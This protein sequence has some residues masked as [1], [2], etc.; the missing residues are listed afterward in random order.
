LIPQKKLLTLVEECRS[1]CAGAAKDFTQQLDIISAQIFERIDEA[2]LAL[3]KKLRPKML[4]LRGKEQ[5]PE[6]LP[7]AFGKPMVERKMEPDWRE[8]FTFKRNCH[9]GSYNNTK[10][11]IH[12]STFL[13]A[14][15]LVQDFKSK[16]TF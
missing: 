1:V 11:H 13:L 5:L 12:L 6:K 16:R 10:I 2:E 4:P 14:S 7:L 15:L 9:H 8:I 3:P